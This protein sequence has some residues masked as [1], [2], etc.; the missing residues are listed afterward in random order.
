MIGSSHLISPQTTSFAASA[1]LTVLSFSVAPGG[2]LLWPIHNLVNAALAINVSR[3]LQIP[4]LTWIAALLLLL[5]GYDVFFVNGSQMLTD[6]GSSIME[7]VARTKLGLDATA[8]TA[9]A[10]TTGAVKAAAATATMTFPQPQ[11]GWRPGLFEVSVGGR[12]S[13]ALGLGDVVFPGILV[14]WARRFDSAIAAEDINEGDD[15]SP[16]AEITASSSGAHIDAGVDAGICNA[17]LQGFLVGCF[18]CEVFQTGQGQPALMFIVP[19]MLTAVLANGAS[20]G[21]LKI[22][23]SREY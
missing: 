13:D 1:A 20:K 8:S 23:F 17:S 6:G 7:S 21:L 22:M 12:V 2:D 4:K 5:V 16:A 19:A 10:S 18:L 11:F 9:V 14:G 3:A 15:V